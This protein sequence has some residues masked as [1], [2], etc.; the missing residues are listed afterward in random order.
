MKRFLLILLTVLAGFGLTACSNKDSDSSS[1]Q[2]AKYT[3]TFSVDGSV[4][5][6]VSDVL[7]G[8]TENFQLILQKK[9]MYLMDGL[10]MELNLLLKQK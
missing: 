10:L 7:N 6:V 4:E 9:V 1:Q 8:T 5:E 3:V 2:D